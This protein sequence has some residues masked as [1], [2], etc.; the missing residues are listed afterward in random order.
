MAW[1]SQFD[2]VLDSRSRVTPRHVDLL[3]SRPDRVSKADVEADHVFG[4]PDET[5]QLHPN[6]LILTA[7]ADC[8]GANRVE[9][10][11]DTVVQCDCGDLP[12]A[13]SDIPSIV[14]NSCCFQI[15][16][17]GRSTKSERCEK[18]TALEY[19]IFCVVGC[20]NSCQHPLQNLEARQLAHV[21][22]VGEDLVLDVGE[23]RRSADHNNTSRDLRS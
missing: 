10:E 16:V 18:H 5:D 21:L 2:V 17:L 7:I 22:G 12:Y 20:R 13:A 23:T 11:L 9:S 6:S 3:G 4:S 15:D 8:L 14:G 19:E 1:C